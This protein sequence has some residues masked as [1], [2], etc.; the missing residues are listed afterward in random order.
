ML[1]EFLLA[2]A[3]IYCSQD[4]LPTAEKLIKDC[5]LKQTEVEIVLASWYGQKFQG[6]KMAN[7][8]RFNKNKPTAAHPTLDFGTKVELINLS[9]LKSETATIEDR[10][11]RALGR[12]IDVS[13]ALAEDLGFKDDGLT[14]LVVRVIEK[15]TSKN[16]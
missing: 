15:P 10:G 7:G 2:L 3:A 16:N 8:E 12:G 4:L 9:N 11:P 13:E 5:D 14:F 6:K 1:A